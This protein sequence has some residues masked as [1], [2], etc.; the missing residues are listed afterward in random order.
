MHANTTIDASA[1]PDRRNQCRLRKDWFFL[2]CND[3]H[4]AKNSLFGGWTEVKGPGQSSPRC[5]GW[6]KMRSIL[7]SSLGASS[8]SHPRL[9]GPEIDVLTPWSYAG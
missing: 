6:Q 3:Q 4:D 9:A 1:K 5:C 7:P 8:A 2:L